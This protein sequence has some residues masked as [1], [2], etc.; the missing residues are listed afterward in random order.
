MSGYFSCALDGSNGLATLFLG[1]AANI[2]QQD[3]CSDADVERIGPKGHIDSQAP[4]ARLDALLWQSMG[5][6]AK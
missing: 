3:P 2:M 6:V 5:F 1:D 4:N